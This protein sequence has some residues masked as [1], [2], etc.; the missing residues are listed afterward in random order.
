M[1]AHKIVRILSLCLLFVTVACGGGEKPTSTPAPSATPAPTATAAPTDTPAATATPAPTATP[2]PSP[3]PQNVVSSLEDVRQATVRIEA[4]GSFIDPEV[5]LQLNVAG[6]GS[7]FI[8]DES[9]LAVTNNHVVTGAA[10]LQVYVEGESRPRNAKILGASECSDLAV[11]DIDGDGFKYLE[12]YDGQIRT[13]LDVYA[14]GY[15]LGDPEYTLT[16]GI[17]S[18]ERADGETNWASVDAVIQHDA[19]INPGNSGGPLVTEDGQVVGVNYAKD[20][21]FDQYFAIARDEALDIIAQ[22]AAGQDVDSIGVNGTAVNDGAGF[23]GIWVSSVKSGSPA[24]R[25]GVQ[26]G[27]VITMI[28]GLIVATDSTMADYCD[29]LRSHRPEDT[30]SLEVVRFDTQEV[31]KGQLNGDPLELAFS[32]ADELADEV[33]G[34][35]GATYSG[36]DLMADDSEAIQIEVPNEWSDV[37]GGAWLVDDQVVGA[38]VAAAP[39]L[40]DFYNTYSTPGV[41]FGASAVLAQ[42]YDEN[43]FLDDLTDYGSDC[44]YEGRFEYTDPIYTGLYDL[45]SN[46][47]DVG[48]QILNIVATPEEGGFIMWVQTQIVNDADLEALDRIINSFEVVGELPAPEGGVSGTTG[49]APVEVTE[50]NGATYRIEYPSAWQESSIEMM[51]LSMSI[52]GPQEVNLLEMED[53]DSLV[54]QDPV[55]LVMAVPEEMTADF[56]FDGIDSAMDEFN[57]AIPDQ[58][59][60]I[61][62][63]GDTTIGGAPGRIVIATGLDPDLGLVGIHLVT[64]STDDG[65][66]IVFMGAT[67]EENLEENMAV[68]RYM[69]ESFTF[70]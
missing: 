34:E 17:V 38:A 7:G 49:T 50:Y 69:Q 22:L 21:N 12:W 37:N 36:Y 28:E 25:A 60:E 57:N 19:A 8:I 32:F 33:P 52:F 66:V 63:Q 30:L 3:T 15:P 51:G 53:F 55:V 4:Q 54:S 27:D 18:K 40:D 56:G 16:S 20:P 64:A 61:I 46:C 6:G 43:A 47:S 5:G 45:Y 44:T 14:A 68:F 70:N 41:F 58:D 65:T 9:G 35:G 11:I 42:S 31:L 23:S 62:E 39:S 24:D 13:G 59:A 26:G 48:S 29:I 67:P 2:E 1:K 10:L